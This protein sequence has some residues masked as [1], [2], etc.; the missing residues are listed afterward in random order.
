M[1]MAEYLRQ[2]FE[3]GQFQEIL[4]QVALLEEKGKLT[5]L[6]L[7]EQVEILYYKSRALEGLGQYEDALQVVMLSHEKLTSSEENGRKI[8]L[9]VARLYALIGL[10]QLEDCLA[11]IKEG[12]A[13]LK[14]LSAVEHEEMVEMVA[15]FYNVKG[16]IYRH[17]GKLD[18]A[19]INYKHGLK[20]QEALENQYQVA[21]SLSNM[22]NIY[23]LKGELDTALEYHQRS[24][25]LKEQVGNPKGIAMSLNNIGAVH[26]AEGKL[27]E[28]LECWKNAT[29]LWEEVG[30]PL[31]LGMTLNNIGEIY[32]IKGELD[33]A[34]EYHQR[35]LALKE[36]VGNKQ[37]IATSLSNIGAIH[38]VRG[39]L[40]TAR[41]YMLHGLT[42]YESIENNL[43]TSFILFSLILVVLDQGDLEQ[44]RKFAAE[45]LKLQEQTPEKVIFLRQRL[46]DALILKQSKRVEDRIRA[47]VLLDEIVNEESIQFELDAHA[48]IHLCDLLLF[49]IKPQDQ[50]EGLKKVVKLTKRLY[51]RAK[52]QQSFPLAIKTLF[53]RAKL[54]VVEGKFQK[55]LYYLKQAK[56][57]AEEK[58]LGLLIQDTV[59]EQ[60]L[61]LEEYDKWKE[62]ILQKNPIQTWLE[63][64]N[65]EEYLKEVMQMIK[66]LKKR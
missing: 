28:A 54:A 63:Q 23:L 2:L 32:R 18:E 27:D 25:A 11:G 5:I 51:T 4:D 47:R 38:H 35:S 17:K 3:K 65:V 41:D 31:A 7:A 21:I 46:A 48:M 60:E 22:G 52:Q 43:D 12:D 44:A 40:L 16:I 55:G 42:I 14:S 58:G 15:L 64:A 33:T 26:H 49:R 8:V 29:V 45:L 61:L 53:L 30:N 62:I 20:L 6:S 24:L 36:Q 39:E 9:L 57:I 37:D 1:V 59:K 10:G 50:S 66:A 19:L 13:I 34:L 56:T